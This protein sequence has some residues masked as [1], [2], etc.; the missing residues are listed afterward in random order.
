M[1]LEEDDDEDRVG[2]RMTLSGRERESVG[3][4]SAI[5]LSKPRG[6]R[7]ADRRKAFL[8]M[9]AYLRAA[10]ANV[11]GG[12]FSRSKRFT[13]KAA[14]WDLPVCRVLKST[15]TWGQL[16]SEGRM[17]NSQTN[18]VGGGLEWSESICVCTTWLAAAAFGMNIPKVTG[19]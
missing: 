8:A 15:T 9:L 16:M 12:I 2:E 13:V 3:N 17:R 6:G 1:T 19:E 4:L 11:G 10:R 5:Y 7:D 18:T 14:K